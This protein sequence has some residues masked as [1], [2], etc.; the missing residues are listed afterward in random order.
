MITPAQLPPDLV[1]ILTP[2]LADEYK[3]FYYYRNASN[4]CANVGFELAAKYFAKESEDELGHAKRIED[5]LVG[6]NVQPALPVGG[7]S[8]QFT[9]LTEII[10]GAYTIEREL[11]IAYNNASTKALATSPAVFNFLAQFTEIQTASVAE[12]SD[13]LNKLKGVDINSKFELLA[14]EESIFG[15]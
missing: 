3:A 10:D 15:V 5:F 2:R 9:A 14:L 11:Y 4:W 1:A 13:M 8:Q 12:Y 7:S 6:W